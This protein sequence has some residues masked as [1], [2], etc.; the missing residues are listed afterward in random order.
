MAC[1]LCADSGLSRK[2]GARTR[3]RSQTAGQ[4]I[5]VADKDQGASCDYDLVY[6]S[7]S[8]N[9]PVP[10]IASLSGSLAADRNRTSQ[11]SPTRLRTHFAWVF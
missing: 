2:I 1:T 4:R 9:V 10:S 6:S 8:E 11:T 5:L 3:I 7:S